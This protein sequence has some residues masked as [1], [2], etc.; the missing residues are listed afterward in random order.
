MAVEMHGDVHGEHPEREAK[1]NQT[2]GI[3][4]CGATYNPR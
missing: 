1:A 4:S 3:K 2:V